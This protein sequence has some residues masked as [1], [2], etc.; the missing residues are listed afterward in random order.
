MSKTIK[1]WER[2]K[3]VG[4]AQVQ[5]SVTDSYKN[6]VAVN[7]QSSSRMRERMVK[8]MMSRPQIKPKAR[9]FK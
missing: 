9:V 7:T 8:N 2:A 6:H 1:V 5:E 4:Y 3:R